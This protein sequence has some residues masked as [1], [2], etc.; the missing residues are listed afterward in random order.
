MIT[1]SLPELGKDSILFGDTK[2]FMRNKAFVMI[3]K[4]FEEKVI[5]NNFIYSNK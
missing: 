4:K 1:N 3:E 2:L 5:S